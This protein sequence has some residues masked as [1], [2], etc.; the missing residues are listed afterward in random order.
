M[1]FTFCHPI[2]ILPLRKSGL[3]F[4]AL[5][6]GSMAPDFL[7]FL[8][9]RT[10]L[11][12]GHTPEGIFTFSLPAGLI[13]FFIFHFSLRHLLAEFFPMNHRLKLAPYCLPFRIPK[14]GQLLLIMLAIVI[15]ATTH[16]LWDA[17]THEDAYFVRL[18]PIL[19]ATVLI[20]FAG[21]LRVYKVLQYS[22]HIFGLPILYFFYRQWIT[23]LPMP[24]NLPGNSE[25]L[26]RPRWKLLAGILMVAG[27]LALA[28]GFYDQYPVHDLESSLKL[29]SAIL[30]AGISFTF[31]GLTVASLIRQKIDD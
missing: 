16:S 7:Y 29:F 31:V 6:I 9:L 5:V 2:A 14:L 25:V 13:V 15:G 18:F 11:F 20:T 17:F 22:G 26:P 24:E 23:S 8:K 28:Y 21:D 3:P 10:G 12:Y 4:S 1:P 30:V 19:D 27:L